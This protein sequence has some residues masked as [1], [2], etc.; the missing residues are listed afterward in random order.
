MQKTTGARGERLALFCNRDEEPMY[1][2]AHP[3]M[4]FA[5]KASIAATA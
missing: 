4:R 2:M 5:M 3:R 1:F